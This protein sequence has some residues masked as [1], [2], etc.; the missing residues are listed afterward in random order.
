[1]TVGEFLLH[2][3]TTSTIKFLVN[4]TH[5]NL[6]KLRLEYGS[7]IIQSISISSRF[8]NFNL[9]DMITKGKG[10]FNNLIINYEVPPETYRANIYIDFLIL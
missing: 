6:R 2:L 10:D 7:S 9:L 8:E 5:I 1:M 3:N 4:G